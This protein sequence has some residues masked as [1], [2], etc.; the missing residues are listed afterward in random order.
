MCAACE[1]TRNGDF[2]GLDEII[3]NEKQH[4]YL[5]RCTRCGA[6]WMGH[7]FTP[8]LF[9]EVNTK[10]AEDAFPGFPAGMS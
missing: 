10:E 1:K 7:A 2:E 9:I 6:L 8:Q 3:A 5:C 4:T